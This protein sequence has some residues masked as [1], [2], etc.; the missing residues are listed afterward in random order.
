[1][2]KINKT[3]CVLLAFEDTGS[4]RNMEIYYKILSKSNSVKPVIAYTNLQSY[5]KSPPWI[6]NKFLYQIPPVDHSVK[7]CKRA[8]C[9]K[10]P[11][12]H[13]TYD[14]WFAD[15]KTYLKIL[16]D[17]VS[18]NCI[19]VLDSIKPE[20]EMHINGPI[21][22][23]FHGELFDIGIS[24]YDNKQSFKRYNLI[25]AQGNKTIDYINK[26]VKLKD[27]NNK[28][29]IIGRLLTEDLQKTKINKAKILSEMGLDVNRKT[30]LYSPSWESRNYWPSN[31]RYS[32][33]KDLTDLCKFCDKEGYNLIIRPHI[34]LIKH[35]NVSD[36]Y[37]K[38]SKRFNNVYFEDTSIYE[39]YNP[40]KSL[41]ISD[42]MITD[43]SSIAVDFLVLKKP[44]I[45]MY[46]QNKILKL[47]EKPPSLA[48]VQ[49]VSYTCTNLDS[50]Y[51]TLK[52]IQ[53]SKTKKVLFS[54]SQHILQKKSLVPS[55]EFRN[56][57]ELLAHRYKSSWKFKKIFFVF[58]RQL[59]RTTKGW[60]I[61]YHRELQLDID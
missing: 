13:R 52:Q 38:I 7:D 11:K 1:M 29:K 31:T 12:D 45:F 56:N 58:L 5:Q 41:K 44:V 19:W 48:E 35:Y 57:I 36:Y 49:K 60:N 21:V 17:T 18:P 33:S 30:I 14:D 61:K 46:P 15:C 20:I 55:R 54:I 22:Q 32:A 10:P 2:K 43:L 42:I 59:L 3:E 27:I 53:S 37:K 8:M 6:K 28:T 26:Y 4:G 25:L 24:Y 51:S 9:N 40:N 16:N 34:I 39:N 23:V 50:L 47:Y